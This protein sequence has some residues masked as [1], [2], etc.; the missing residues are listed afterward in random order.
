MVAS[1]LAQG[2]AQD[3]L[4]RF[5]AAR[6]VFRQAFARAEISGDD[7]QALSA[8]NSLM[9][10]EGCRLAQYDNSWRYQKLAQT[11]GKRLGLAGIHPE[12]AEMQNNLGCV[13][14]NQGHYKESMAA[15][16]K[17]LSILINTL[18]TNH[19]QV[20]SPLRRLGVLYEFENDF[21]QAAIFYKKALA[22]A[23]ES[24]GPE[25]PDV[26]LSLNNLGVVCRKK[27]DS[28]QA[29]KFY[30]D[31][32]SILRRSLGED[33]AQLPRI[34]VDLSNLGDLNRDRGDYQ[35]AIGY[36]QRARVI[37]E[38]SF[39]PDD[40]RLTWLFAGM[41]EAYM[42]QG[43]Y[44]KAQTLLQRALRLCKSRSCDAEPHGRA[45]FALARVCL[46]TRTD[47]QSAIELAQ[48]AMNAYGKEPRLKERVLSVHAWLVKQG[49]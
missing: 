27:G 20:A 17:A 10:T 11:V 9:N 3:Q 7:M 15:F 46:A 24:F 49:D 34:A 19:P 16:R 35:E 4:G 44:A 22:I 40:V 43:K 29:L 25:H 14:L 2:K 39:G 30:Q 47:R 37:F 32:L 23:K 1:L 21:T 48:Q 26:A 28:A 31:A 33:H 12:I 42:M 36:Y 8:A 45:L 13:L 5:D 41:G 18:G 38:K 6:S